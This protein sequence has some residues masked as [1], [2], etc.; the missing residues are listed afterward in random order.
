MCIGLSISGECEYGDWEK[1][2]ECEEEYKKDERKYYLALF[3]F[4]MFIFHMYYYMF[5][6]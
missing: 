4:S 5:I 3:F 6:Q 1:R 2:K